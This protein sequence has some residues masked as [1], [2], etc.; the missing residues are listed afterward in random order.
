MSPAKVFP[1]LALMCYC[2]KFGRCAVALAVLLQFLT[3]NTNSSGLLFGIISQH[4][5]ANDYVF[6]LLLL[7]KTTLF[8]IKVMSFNMGHTVPQIVMSHIL[9]C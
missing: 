6:Y 9:V 2:V 7:L 8:N 5:F 4:F 3:V 1:S